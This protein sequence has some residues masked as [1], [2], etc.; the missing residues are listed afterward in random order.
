MKR[1]KYFIILIFCIFVLQACKKQEPTAKP[2]NPEIELEEG[3][4][5]E[6]TLYSSLNENYIN[7]SIVNEYFLELTNKG[8]FYF[9]E[10]ESESIKDEE[11][12]TNKVYYKGKY[13]ETETKLLLEYDEYNILGI[14][15]FTKQDGL[16][17]VKEKGI[18]FSTRMSNLSESNY[19]GLFYSIIDE[20]I[21]SIEL[22][23]NNEA[24]V[25]IDDEINYCTYNVNV[26]NVYIRELNMNLIINGT[27]LIYGNYIFE[28]STSSKIEVVGFVTNLK[29]SITKDEDFDLIGKYVDVCYSDFKKVRYY[30]TK[31]MFNEY[32]LNPG[33]NKL[34]INLDSLKYEYEVYVI[35][36]ILV[37]DKALVETT[38][39]A[40]LKIELANDLIIKFNSKYKSNISLLDSKFNTIDSSTNK[41][42]CFIPNS[43]ESLVYVKIEA[44]AIDASVELIDISKTSPTGEYQY[45]N[46]NEGI[47]LNLDSNSYEFYYLNSKTNEKIKHTGKYE[48][49]NGIIKFDNG[50]EIKGNENY[51]AYKNVLLEKKNNE[52]IFA[53][54]INERNSINLDDL[55][56]KK[57][58]LTNKGI[59]EENLTK[60]EIIGYRKDYEGNY[61][62]VANIKGIYAYTKVNI[63]V[64][65]DYK[66]SCY[67]SNINSNIL[68]KLTVT[69]GEY[70]LNLSGDDEYLIDIYDYNYNLIK[71][72]GDL[73]PIRLNGTYYIRVH[74][75]SKNETQLS[76]DGVLKT[77]L[78]GKYTN[79]DQYIDFDLKK[80]NDLDFTFDD[81]YIH[82]GDL[83]YEYKIYGNIIIIDNQ[84][85]ISNINSNVNLNGTYQLES[86]NEVMIVEINNNEITYLYTTI[87]ENTI[88]DYDTNIK[89]EGNKIISKI[90]EFYYYF[91]Q[92]KI[93]LLYAYNG[94]FVELK[95][96][97]LNKEIVDTK[98]TF[99][100]TTFFVGD[101]LL[102]SDIDILVLY[103][104][105]SISKYEFDSKNIKNF[106]TQSNGKLKY[107]LVIGN[108]EYDCE[109]SVISKSKIYLNRKI[110]DYRIS[111][112]VYEFKATLDGDYLISIETKLYSDYKVYIYNDYN[113][114]SLIKEFPSNSFYASELINCKKNSAYYIYVDIPKKSDLS[115]VIS[116][117]TSI[118][119]TYTYDINKIIF[120]SNKSFEYNDNINSVR[121][122][123]VYESIKKNNYRLIVNKQY[124]I[125]GSTYQ[126]VDITTTQIDVLNYGD[127]VII[128]NNYY[129]NELNEINYVGTYY[130]ISNNIVK[131]IELLS[132]ESIGGGMLKKSSSAID[133]TQ[134]ASSSIYVVEGSLLKAEKNGFLYRENNYTLLSY[135]NDIYIKLDNPKGINSTNITL[136]KDTYAIGEVFEVDAYIT[137]LYNDSKMEK[138]KVTNSMV[139]K[140]INTN[141]LG[142]Y[143][144]TIQY[145]N[146][147]FN[148]TIKVGEIYV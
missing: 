100:K 70:I 84:V 17:I 144:V 55:I 106:T 112:K 110:E 47:Y 18:A 118:I 77:K 105:G 76:I 143:L 97:P 78:E 114:K 128:E 113:L 115:I 124:Q 133:G 109:Y 116:L 5:I 61:N 63:N 120:N 32:T 88:T 103:S 85:Y 96:K 31:D 131:K 148:V 44:D 69:D 136:N 130:S 35:N 123:G 138:I 25:R 142:N 1:I 26:S 107:T 67:I 91:N 13:S 104:N 59:I 126:E 99:N 90:G 86:S 40:Y 20:S 68:Y 80:F 3:E 71:T 92:D 58:C 64:I 24:I 52:L 11:V 101:E 93:N 36:E 56:I 140:T 49:S 98:V 57:V 21:Y 43:N 38:G 41:V 65:L 6:K 51:I 83:S 135:D 27:T 29:K 81:D 39:Y 129:V 66:D 62:I 119:G 127:I 79:S 2:V 12:S 48:F 34:T 111:N 42:G 33:Y 145:K 4:Y 147:A 15:E 50:I 137:I 45:S 23:T 94:S 108:E 37:K 46:D 102:P 60:D 19:I 8:N 73:T 117:D 22:K 16:Y 14:D 87:Q 9:T 7:T 146:I 125:E 74:C 75:N 122:I 139:E 95:N 28:R 53:Y 82:V 134:E 89:L 72:I 132:E 121:Y 30:I 10:N 54:L 141:K